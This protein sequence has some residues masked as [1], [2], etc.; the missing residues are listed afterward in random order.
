M[1]PIAEWLE[2]LGLGQYGKRFVENGIDISALA[3]LTDQDF[4]DLG[5]LLGHRRKMQAAIAELPGNA[6]RTTRPE[7]TPEPKPREDAERRHLTVMFTDLVGSTALSTQLDP[8]DLR[9]V[10]SA[11]H[12]CVAQTVV[13]FDGFVAKYMG[14]GALIYFGYPQAHEDDAERAV[15]AA[16]ALVEAVPKPKTAAG[17]PLQVRIGV[18]TGTGE[19]W[20]E[21]EANRMRGELLLK[22]QQPD[23]GAV[24]GAFMRAIEI[25][26]SQH[27][28]TFELRATL[29]LAKLYRATGRNSGVRELLVAAVAGFTKG[30]EVPEVAEVNRFLESLDESPRLPE[31]KRPA[32]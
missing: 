4:K 7:T 26:R 25:A 20:F 32:T 3:H 22:L 27:T 12:K 16:L 2:T 11:Y 21:A 31:E 15:R 9:S 19:R 30:A 6:P 8:E 28:R 13:P 23:F 17:A 5:V 24:E 10:I 1:E 29:S 18:A 14:D